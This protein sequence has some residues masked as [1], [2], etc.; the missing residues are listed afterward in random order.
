DWY[1]PGDGN[2]YVHGADAATGVASL[3]VI[4]ARTGTWLQNVPNTLGA[5]PSAYA[6]TNEIFTRVQVNAAIVAGTAPDNSRCVVK[7]RGCVVVF[8]H[9]Q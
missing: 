5:S 9:V 3:G 2:F 4:D 8:S 6:H 7:R 1:N